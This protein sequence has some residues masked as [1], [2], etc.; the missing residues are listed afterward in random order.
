MVLRL[1]S[2]EGIASREG[3][4]DLACFIEE[5]SGAGP[6]WLFGR[7]SFV[8]NDEVAVSAK[9]GSSWRIRFDT[10]TLSAVNPVDKCTDAPDPAAD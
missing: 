10:K 9:D 7:A 3:I 1:Q 4:E 6:D 2:R 5:S 8:D